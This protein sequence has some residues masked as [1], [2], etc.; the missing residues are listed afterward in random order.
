MFQTER[1]RV[2]WPSIST[3]ASRMC[4]G[5]TLDA[6]L[7]QLPLVQPQSQIPGPG[8]LTQELLELLVGSGTNLQE[9]IRE[10]P[11]QNGY[12]PDQGEQVRPEPSTAC[13]P[14]NPPQGWPPRTAGEAGA[15]LY[16]P[17]PLPQV[18]SSPNKSA[19]PRL[20]E[21]KKSWEQA[22]FPYWFHFP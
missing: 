22:Q 20:D 9:M 19:R 5:A 15:S 6:A 14:L 4:P 21:Q 12:L 10:L 13:W 8:E 11:H 16:P 18:R 1:G 17:A 2:L 7:V 3:S